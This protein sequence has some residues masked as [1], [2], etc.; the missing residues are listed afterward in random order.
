MSFVEV[1]S[2]KAALFKKCFVCVFSYIFSTST[3]A[4]KTPR[5]GL[6]CTSV[7]RTGARAKALISSPVKTALTQ[8]Q[9]VKQPQKRKD[10]KKI[11]FACAYSCACVNIFLVKTKHE[12]TTRNVFEIFLST[13][14]ITALASRIVRGITVNSRVRTCVFSS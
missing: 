1:Y 6:V 10:W 8:E 14:P 3:T 9:E 13:K 4:F 7:A 11:P 5:L 2:A 12:E